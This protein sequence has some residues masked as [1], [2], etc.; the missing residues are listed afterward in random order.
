MEIGSS[1]GGLIDL[2]VASSDGGA[3]TAHE[4]RGSRLAKVCSSSVLFCFFFFSRRQYFSLTKNQPTV[5]FNRLIIPAERGRSRE[6]SGSRVAKSRLERRRGAIRERR[7]ER[8]TGG[9]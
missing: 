1:V 9:G 5:F 7:R 8:S 3:V 2:S 6:Q 4:Q